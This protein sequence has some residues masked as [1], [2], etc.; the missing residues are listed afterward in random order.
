MAATLT[1][2]REHSAA[3]TV[4]ADRWEPIRPSA[5]S[6]TLDDELVHQAAMAARSLPPDVD[7]ALARFVEGSDRS[8]ALMLRNVA[9]GPLPP[10]P[11]SPAAPIET[12]CAI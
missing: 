2:R 3:P 1:T 10:T 6:E 5:G 12:P 4:D 9:V 7:E 11:P 8:G